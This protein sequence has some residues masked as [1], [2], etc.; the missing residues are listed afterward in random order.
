MMISKCSLTDIEN[1]RSLFLHETNFQFVHDKCHLYGWAD[2]YIFNGDGQSMGYGSVWGLNNRT[3]RDTIFEFYVL[4]PYRRRA[5]ELFGEF[6][7]G[8]NPIFIECQSNDYLLSSMFFEFSQN[9]YA[10][11]TLFEDTFQ[12]NF[13]IPGLTLEKYEGER[14]TGIPM[15]GNFI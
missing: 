6:I 10:E 2:N 11:S 7:R 5:H 12:T 15:T 13:S 3:D 4:P 1:L 14:K 8:S 9:I